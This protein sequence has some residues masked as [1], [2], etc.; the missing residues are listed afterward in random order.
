[1]LNK[2]IYGVWV[3]SEILSVLLVFCICGC[4]VLCC[5]VCVVVCYCVVCVI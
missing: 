5:F 4:V 1:M 2:W 3:N